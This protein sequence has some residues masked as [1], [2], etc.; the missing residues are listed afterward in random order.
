MKTPL[1][2]ILILL[3]IVSC[4]PQDEK[5]IVKEVVIDTHA[6]KTIELEDM[7]RRAYNIFLKSPRE[8]LGMYFKISNEYA[9]IGNVAKQ[10]LI[11]LNISNIYDEYTDD[12][13]KA[14]HHG[15]KSLALWESLKDTMQIANLFKYCGYLSAKEG[16]IDYGKMQLNKAEQLY[17]GLSY[18]QG[19]AI[20]HFNMARVF[21]MEKNYEQAQRFLKLS[22]TFWTKENDLGRIFTLNNFGIELNKETHNDKEVKALISENENIMT[23][24][25]I[26]KS[27]VSKFDQLRK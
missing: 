14:S 21:K 17:F 9:A 22:K 11:E 12:V 25:K 5:P 16:A 2:K 13:K 1:Y 20:T 10:A 8:S 18:P 7:E 24:E 27:Q 19:T 3:L 15:H 4:R 6:A 23:R 26:H